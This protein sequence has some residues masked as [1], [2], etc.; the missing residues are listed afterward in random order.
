LSWRRFETARFPQPQAKK[1]SQK[2]IQILINE[3]PNTLNSMLRTTLNMQKT[4]KITWLSPLKNDDYAEYRD[5]AALNLL[6]VSFD[7]LQKTAFWTDMGPQW[8]GIARTSEK[9]FLIEAKSHISEL[10]SSMKAKDPASIAIIKNSLEKTKEQLG[11]KSDFDWTKT[12]YQYANRL[13]HVNFLRKLYLPAYLVCV[14][15]VNDSEMKGP[16]SVEE[17]KGAIRLLHRCLGL[18]GPLIQK[19]VVD[20]FIDITSLQGR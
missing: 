1:G 12:F 16:T 5:E 20:I 13:A 18:R 6:G 8:D 15:F 7:T 14:Y 10:I 17:W 3:E 19:W 11:S 2:W 9:T 4:E